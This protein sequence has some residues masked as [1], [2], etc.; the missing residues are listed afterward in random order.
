MASQTPLYT[1]EAGP[2]FDLSGFSAGRASVVRTRGSKTRVGP[3]VQ[4]C[5][6]ADGRVPDPPSYLGDLENPGKK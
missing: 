3:G 6:G 2:P 1:T 5:N 4:V